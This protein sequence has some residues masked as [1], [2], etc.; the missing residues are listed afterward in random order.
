VESGF[1]VGP[2]RLTISMVWF[3]PR[4]QM[5]IAHSVPLRKYF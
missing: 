5:A 2:V 3:H 4:V 1:K